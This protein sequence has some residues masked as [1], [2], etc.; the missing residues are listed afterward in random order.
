MIKMIKSYYVLCY[1]NGSLKGR[2]HRVN[3]CGANTFTFKN[4]LNIIYCF[5]GWQYKTRMVKK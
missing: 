5:D 3:K 4:E 1:R 2:W